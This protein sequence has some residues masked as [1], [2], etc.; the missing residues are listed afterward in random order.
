MSPG[1]LL[2]RTLVAVE[3]VIQLSFVKDDAVPLEA[4]KRANLHDNNGAV[5]GAQ[6]SA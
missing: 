4:I 2:R 1:S 6:A 5:R 3:R